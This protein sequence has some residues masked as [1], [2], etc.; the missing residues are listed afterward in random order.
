[1]M[2]AGPPEIYICVELDCV[3]R[4]PWPPQKYAHVIINI[5]KKLSDISNSNRILFDTVY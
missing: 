1:M 5:K 3:I 2:R 4:Y